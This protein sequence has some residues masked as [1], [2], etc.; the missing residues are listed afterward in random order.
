MTSMG[1]A[2]AMV[3]AFAL[4]AAI[5][6]GF[7]GCVAGFGTALI[8]YRIGIAIR[9]LTAG[10]LEAAVI[11][12]VLTAIGSDG[13][14]LP[15]M[16]H[17]DLMSSAL[18]IFALSGLFAM[19]AYSF[20]YKG[21][22]MCG[23]ALGMACNCMYAFW[24]PLFMWLLLGVAGIGGMPQ[25][26]PP[27]SPAQWIGAGVMVAGIFCIAW[28]A[29]VERTQSKGRSRGPA[30][31]TPGAQG[32]PYPTRREAPACKI[33][34]CPVA[35]RRN[36]SQCW[37]CRPRAHPTIWTAPAV[38]EGRRKRRIGDEQGERLALYCHR[39]CCRA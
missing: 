27:L 16:T 10:V 18:P 34:D 31:R 28:G 5:G 29:T 12:P 25:N 21:N 22:S 35:C 36:C 17:A 1:P 20:W 3:C 6:W 11:F 7:E 8:D 33:R 32:G 30:P 24:A 4:F 14:A 26:Y 13:S 19:P 9:Q 38:G 15:A 2:A 37:R 23:A 39:R